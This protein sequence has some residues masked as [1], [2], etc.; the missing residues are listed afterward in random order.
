MSRFLLLAELYRLMAAVYVLARFK[1]PVIV[2]VGLILHGIYA[3]ALGALFG[4]IKI[5]LLMG[6][7]DLGLTNPSRKCLQAVLI[8]C[9]CRAD[10]IGTRGAFSRKWLIEQGFAPDRLFIAHNVFD[11]EQFRPDPHVQ[12]KYDLIYVGLLAPYKRLDLLLDVV[13][14]LVF[15][16]NL[17]TLQLAIVG[18]GSQKAELQRE[19]AR[20]K[21]DGNVRFLPPGNASHVCKML[22]RSRVFVMTS[23][24]E[25]LPMAMIEAM[26]CGV[27]PVVFDDA[28]MGD[29]VRHGENGLLVKPRDVDAFV[30]AVVE[31]LCD[32]QRLDEMTRS[33]STIRDQYKEAYS[34]E[35]MRAVWERV[36][37]KCLR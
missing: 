34:L 37:T 36:L 21:V 17:S 13:R 7:N 11:F 16:K 10:F 6:K 14:Q 33:A 28:D 24:G 29:V 3:N 18:D 30:D 22:N 23:Q 27:P 31:L 35:A 4:K 2:G 8:R 1:P 5:L 26:S 12:K 15:E 32:R 20:K 19:A 9:A 25:G